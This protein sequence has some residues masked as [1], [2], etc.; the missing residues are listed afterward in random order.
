[1][2]I[3]DGLLI[4]VSRAGRHNPSLQKYYL[5]GGDIIGVAMS[6]LTSLPRLPLPMI[7]SA[8]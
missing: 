6:P 8:T 1:M 5:C 3:T 4:K 2:A 7:L